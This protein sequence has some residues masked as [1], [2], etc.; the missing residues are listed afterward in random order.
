[1]PSPAL[2]GI[3]FAPISLV[4]GGM[5]RRG[6]QIC[7]S[8]CGKSDTVRCNT[9]KHG[10]G[11]DNE[12]LEQ[13]LVRKF[14]RLGWRIGTSSSRDLCMKCA[15]NHP[16]L[17]LVEG[18]GMETIKP[19][20]ISTIVAP[21]PIREMGADEALTILSKLQEVYIDKDKG[22]DRGWTDAKVGEDLNVPRA[23]V[24][25]VRTKF[26]GAGAA[27]NDD[28]NEALE[29]ARRV[30][31]EGQ[32]LMSLVEQVQTLALKVTNESGALKSRLER[33]E[34]QLDSV[35]TSLRRG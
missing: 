4:S 2:N 5:R 28:I 8:K 12:N 10:G 25:Q 29:E 16:A 15:L 20:T 24:T 13:L 6:Y 17:K 11:D 35:E 27:G 33:V 19:G 31:K 23:W 32:A 26:Y 9:L 30:V 34:R 21:P 1:M 7:C 22:Y 3:R 18:S 14:K